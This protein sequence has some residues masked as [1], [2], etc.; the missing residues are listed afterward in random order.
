MVID[1]S[2]QAG[3]TLKLEFTAT[4]YDS[5]TFTPYFVLSNATSNYSVTG[6]G[7]YEITLAAS[8]TALWV[9]GE[10]TYTVYVSDG[11][12]R[13]TIER[14][15]VKVLP[16]ITTGNVDART[17]NKKILEAIEATIQGAATVGQQQT[18]I[19]GRAI[20]RYSPDELLKM[21]SQFKRLV[22]EEEIKAKFGTTSKKIFVRF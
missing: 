16:D 15:T 18:S 5:A 13:Y 22:K 14:G 3:D 21:H 4:D 11:T 7:D 2:I 6:S 8:V 1:K 17:T 9:A 10:Y 20:V 12:D 19:N